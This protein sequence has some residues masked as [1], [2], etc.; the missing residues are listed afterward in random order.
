VAKNVLSV[1]DIGT[2]LVISSERLL[3]HPFDDANEHWHSAD[4]SAEFVRSLLMGLDA[5]LFLNVM[6]GTQTSFESRGRWA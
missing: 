4:A 6:L 1:L 5:I 2:H 3:D